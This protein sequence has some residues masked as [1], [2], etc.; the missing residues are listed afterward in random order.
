MNLFHTPQ[1]AILFERFR[2]CGSDI[3]KDVRAAADGSHLCAR[4]WARIAEEGLWRTLSA[5][6]GDPRPIGDF[7]AAV[8]G[9]AAGTGELGFV[10]SAIAHGGGL[11][12]FVKWGNEEQRRRYLPRMLDGGILATAMTER[13]GG[14]SVRNIAT[15]AVERSGRLVL[16]GE[17]VHIT[18]APVADTL[19]FLGRIPALEPRDM[20]LF[21]VERTAEGVSTSAP[22]K[23]IGLDGSPTGAIFFK[24]AL[25]G[26]D[27][28]LG[29]RG[30]GLSILYE[31]L[32]LDRALYGVVG[33]AIGE[34][35]LVE[36]LDFVAGHHSLGQPLHAHQYVQQMIVDI[37][38]KLEISRSLSQNALIA[39]ET[40][41]ERASALCSVAKLV[42]TENM[43]DIARDFVE[44]FGHSGFERGRQSQ[45][46]RDAT[47]LLMA[48]GTSAIQ[49]VNIF[50]RLFNERSGVA[51]GD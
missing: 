18:N 33:A 16:N 10:L 22:E 26:P 49:K 34:Q 35:I 11:R 50:R 12:I 32:W 21:I 23:L 4:S 38:V 41:P 24:D 8:E 9:L 40:C 20:T 7:A 46:L 43:F 19:I 13:S 27:N 5:G 39:M 31:M 30:E 3:R 2:A 48:G 37:K 15:T 25:I 44:I 47:G 36:S 28:V 1:Q 51:H 14:S 6:P 42:G 45:T 29:G 17:K